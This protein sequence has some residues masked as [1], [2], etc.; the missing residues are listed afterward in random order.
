MNIVFLSIYVKGI[1]GIAMCL[2]KKLVKD[3]VN[4]LKPIIEN[5]IFN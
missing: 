2:N 1:S 3:L 4:R 5:H